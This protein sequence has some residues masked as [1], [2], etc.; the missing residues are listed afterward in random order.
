MSSEW[1]IQRLEELRG[2]PVYDREGEKI[3]KVEEIF[4]DLQTGEPEWLGLG[5]GFFGT[6]R[7]LVPVAGAET[8][9]DGVLVR[10]GKEQVKDSPYIDSDEISPQLESELY[11]YYGLETA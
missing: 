8:H 10:Y 2:S 11:H 9:D 7:V 1:T 4:Y 3:G 6:K 5:A